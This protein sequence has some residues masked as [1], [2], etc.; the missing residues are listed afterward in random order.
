[1]KKHTMNSKAPA[2]AIVAEGPEQHP[3]PKAISPARKVAFEVLLRIGTGQRHCDELLQSHLLHGLSQEDKNLATALV[4]GV[5]RWQ[6]A[7]DALVVPLLNRPA[8]K[9]AAPVAIALRI[10]AFQ[11]RYLDRIPAHAV[12]SESVELCRAGGEPHA[13]GM[14]N[15]VLRKIAQLPAKDWK[16]HT[17]TGAAAL[18]LQFA[19]PLWLVERWVQLYGLES[20]AA[21]CSAG[22]QQPPAVLRY[23]TEEDTHVV[24]R[25]ES[26]LK[27]GLILRCARIGTAAY[28]AERVTNTATGEH[29]M[30]EGS[31]LVAE[32]AAQGLPDAGSILDCCAAPGGKTLVLA[33]RNPSA[34]VLAS[35][36]SVRRLQEMEHRLGPMTNAG[37]IHFIHADAIGAEDGELFDRILCDVPCSG[38]GTLARNP[39][40]RHRLRPEQLAVHA[41][42]QKA[43]LR[44]SLR[45]LKPGGRLLYSTCSLEPE[46]NE[47]V[48][49]ACLQAENGFKT[50]DIAEGIAALGARGIVR[51]DAAGML[52]RTAV[53]AGCLRTLPGVHPCDGFFAAMIERVSVV[54]FPQSRS[55][56]AGGWMV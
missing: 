30:D 5:L 36:V 12:L 24:S 22:Q 14:V 52:M 39:E 37:N 19:H 6:I 42:K 51:L 31:Q 48:V 15:A 40:I 23:V 21:I 25:P 54:E 55:G 4:M 1:M 47:A 41:E 27:E 17:A 7:L 33:E 56:R 11:L 45:R 43:I 13:T 28:V 18:A 46:E 49:A 50:I 32:L 16:L 10:G 29:A 9:L 2:I 35:D 26:E 53:L 38:T 8:Q 34:Q 44:A 20:T 3:V